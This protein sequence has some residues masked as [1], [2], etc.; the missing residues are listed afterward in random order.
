MSCW[1]VVDGKPGYEHST[2]PV[3]TSAQNTNTPHTVHRQVMRQP[4]MSLEYAPLHKTQAHFAVIHLISAD[5]GIVKFPAR[6]GDA[7]AQTGEMPIDYT[8]LNG[9]YPVEFRTVPSL[10]E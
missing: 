10:I 6:M 5:W 8:D 7:P 4:G 9:R 3:P 2:T 1:Q